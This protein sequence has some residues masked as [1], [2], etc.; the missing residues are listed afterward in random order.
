VE[1]CRCLKFAD[2]LIDVLHH[3]E[4]D[5]DSSQCGSDKIASDV[6][7]SRSIISVMIFS[8]A[9]NERAFSHFMNFVSAG[10]TPHDH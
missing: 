10:I 8:E 9:S 2:E 6:D 5:P 4:W 1:G 3:G 7:L